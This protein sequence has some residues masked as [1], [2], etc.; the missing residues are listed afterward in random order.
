GAWAH[1]L[2][3]G[4]VRLGFDPLLVLVEALLVGA[5]VGFGSRANRFF[6]AGGVR[7]FFEQRTTDRGTQAVREP[8]THRPRHRSLLRCNR[9]TAEACAR[10]KRESTVEHSC[11]P[12]A[13]NVTRS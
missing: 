11:D 5:E 6:T 1:A 2:A 3:T 12:R 4:E 8:S 7:A 9:R 10:P 13:R